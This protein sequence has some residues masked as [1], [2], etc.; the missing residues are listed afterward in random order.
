MKLEPGY[1]NPNSDSL[2]IGVT[3]SDVAA[4]TIDRGRRGR[5]L[6]S[7]PYHVS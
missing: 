4:G 7:Y 1:M 5:C 3:P 2:Q 6:S